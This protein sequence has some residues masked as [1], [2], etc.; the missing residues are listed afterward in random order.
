MDV[1]EGEKCRGD[2]GQGRDTGSAHKV[3][4]LHQSFLCRKGAGQLGSP[5]K[6]AEPGGAGSSQ[7]PELQI[8]RMVPRLY[9]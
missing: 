2:R 4:I 6:N 9:V 3:V 1:P 5:Q 7:L 8:Q